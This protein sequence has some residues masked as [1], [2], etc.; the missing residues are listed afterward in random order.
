MNNEEIDMLVQLG[1]KIANAGYIVDDTNRFAP[2]LIVEPPFDNFVPTDSNSY[3]FRA[4]KSFIDF[5]S[6]HGLLFICNAT[7]WDRLHLLQA[8]YYEICK[9]G[10]SV[11]FLGL[12][13]STELKCVMD[14]IPDVLIMSE[15]QEWEY[16]DAELLEILKIYISSS[17]QK[18]LIISSDNMPNKT[19]NLSSACAQSIT[20]TFMVAP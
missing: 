17:N 4:T 19:K 6:P 7:A 10:K 5:D 15:I 12:E 14:E 9:Q 18:R 1:E 8:T 13:T 2:K 11:E 16:D 3:A 20:S